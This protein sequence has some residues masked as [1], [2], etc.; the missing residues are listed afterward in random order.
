MG[1]VC[2]LLLHHTAL[3]KNIQCYGEICTLENLI[4]TGMDMPLLAVLVVH[5]L[6]G[7]LW[8]G[9]VEFFGISF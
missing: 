3:N 5:S 4:L 6:H 1:L 7:I 8:L 2:V 9:C